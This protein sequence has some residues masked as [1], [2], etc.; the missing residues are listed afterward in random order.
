V[1]DLL[2][3]IELNP[4]HADAANDPQSKKGGSRETSTQTP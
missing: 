2:A 3:E 4:Y 1:I